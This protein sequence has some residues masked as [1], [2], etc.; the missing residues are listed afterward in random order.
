M[1]VDMQECRLHEETVVL[2]TFMALIVYLL[3]IIKI[4]NKTKT[5]IKDERYMY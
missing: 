3:V 1:Y 5:A 4:K 2:C